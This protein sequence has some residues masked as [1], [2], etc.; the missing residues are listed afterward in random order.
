MFFGG[1]LQQGEE[2]G[3]FMFER[4]IFSVARSQVFIFIRTCDENGV[5]FSSQVRGHKSTA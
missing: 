3:L 1:R 5:E 2:L 4:H